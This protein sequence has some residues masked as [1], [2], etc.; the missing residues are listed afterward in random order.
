MSTAYSYTRFSSPAQRTGDSIRRQTALRDAWL[1]RNGLDLDDTLTLQDA[2][3]SAFR[4]RHRTDP[5]NALGG[6]LKLVEA[7]RVPRGSYFIIESLDRLSR[8]EAE[9]ALTLPVTIPRAGIKVVQLQPVETVYAK[10]VD[11]MKL[12]MAVMEMSRG[13]SESR[14]KSERSAAAW[15]QKRKA[16]VAGKMADGFVPSWI[17]KE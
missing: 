14:M 10:P 8:E 9:E 6:F 4:G 13:H 12:V 7:G 2:G 11:P 1:A 3:V 15:V 17:R 5:R 16:A